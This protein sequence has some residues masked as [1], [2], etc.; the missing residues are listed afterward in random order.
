MFPNKNYFKPVDSTNMIRFNRFTT[1]E[2]TV[3]TDLEFPF[4]TYSLTKLAHLPAPL[5]RPPFFTDV[6]GLIVAVSDTMQYHSSSRAQPFVKRIVTIRDLSGYQIN[7]VLWGEHATVFDAE[8]VITIGLTGPVFVL[9]V[10]T[11]VK[12]YEG[13][14]GV[15][16][17]AACRWYIND[18]ITEISYFHER[19]QGK[20]SP[21]EKI[22]LPGQTMAQVAAH[23]EMET[24]TVAELLA[25]DIYKHKE[26]SFF[27]SITLARLSPGQRWWFMCCEKCH[28]TSQPYGSVYRC[29]DTK[30]SCTDARPRYR[31]CFVGAD[32]TG[33]AEFVLFDRAG[34]DAVDKSLITLLREGNS[35]RMPLNEVVQMARGTDALPR[36]L[37]TLIGQKYRFVVSIS[38]KSFQPEAEE[39]SYQVNRID[40]PVEKGSRSTVEYRKADSS[41]QFESD[42]GSL[43]L[44]GVADS[45][46]L[47]TE[48]IPSL[49]TTDLHSL[50]QSN[51]ATT[52]K[53]QPGRGR[54]SPASVNK[55]LQYQCKADGKEQGAKE[56]CACASASSSY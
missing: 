28:K 4:Y 25:L 11:L 30:C 16:G 7:V 53:A 1:V 14:R 15:S 35:N 44:A 50:V 32:D 24:K 56:C 49:T 31:I 54:A 20:F 46:V 48:S 3:E 22:R 23:V 52:P 47:P 5:E 26:A 41:E 29:N 8:E 39:T 38:S 40:V 42:T 51:E 18:D 34:R 9:F 37:S 55:V 12:N 45:T 43:A 33:E 27:T 13:R 17:S 19:L 6:L 21:V 10:G 36:E 2:P